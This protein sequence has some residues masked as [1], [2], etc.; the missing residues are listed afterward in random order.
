MKYNNNKLILFCLIACIVSI[1]TSEGRR[2][3]KTFE[4]NLDLAPEK[5][6]EE[7]LPT[8]NKTVWGFYN[9]YFAK[10]K[11]LTDI[12]YGLAD[13]RGPENEEQQKE[14]E[15]LADL[16]KLPLKFV[17]GIQMLYEI[18][19]LMV[20]IV[21]FTGH[22]KRIDPIPEGYEALLKLPWHGGCTGIIARNSKDNTVYHARNLDFSPVPVMTNLVYNGVFTKGRKEIFRSQMIAG[23]TM[24]I[25]AFKAGKDGYAIERNTRY[26]DHWGGNKEMID[27]LESGRKLN[28]WQLRK[29]L[30]TTDTFDDAIQ[31][32]STIPYAS[33][34][35]A[36]VSGVQ[37]GQIISRNPDNVAYRQVLG[38]KNFDEPD[39]YIIITNFDFFYH[40]IREQFDPTAGGGFK[41]PTRR[42][43]AQKILNS[44][45]ALTPQVLF[46]TINAEY[47]LAD[48]VFQA[49]INVELGLWNISQPDLKDGVVVL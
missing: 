21:N 6:Y 18:Q 42:E 32:I 25:T 22:P 35:Y 48:T 31:K 24:V 34:E 20:P 26:T 2:A 7:L 10:D 27:N 33:T 4:I 41:K 46:D 19:T 3:V 17:Q 14:I 15:G 12:L 44:S 36:I 1:T 47:V 28:G 16:S 5:R 45:T 37:K 9:K 40:D 8:Y 49:I 29:I 43:A 23:Y 38:Q 39:D 30:E 11:I 13:K